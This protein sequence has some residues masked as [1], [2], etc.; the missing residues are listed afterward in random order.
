M[1]IWY[2]VHRDI[3]IDMCLIYIER[4][5]ER[6]RGKK[7]VMRCWNVENSNL[8]C[9]E[10]IFSL[11][12]K[13]LDLLNTIPSQVSLKH[14]SIYIYRMNTFYFSGPVYMLSLLL[15]VN[16]SFA[17]VIQPET[18]EESSF[19]RRS[20]TCEVHHSHKEMRRGQCVGERDTHCVESSEREI[21]FDDV[22]YAD[23][24]RENI[25]SDEIGCCVYLYDCKV[26]EPDG[27]YLI[28]LR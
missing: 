11:F 18:D 9:F 23:V 22:L 21:V 5:R 28:V 17:S 6:E 20:M 16:F 1:D 10:D 4:E 26:E 3:E 19:R 27:T 15:L 24:C 14:T 25:P 2:I 8:Q 12:F 13:L 7:R